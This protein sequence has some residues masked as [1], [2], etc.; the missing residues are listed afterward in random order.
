LRAFVEN[1]EGLPLSEGARNATLDRI[2]DFTGTG[3]VRLRRLRRTRRVWAA[4]ASVLVL[5]S[6]SL[7]W[8]SERR[9]LRASTSIS[10][11]AEIG[12]GGNRAI[13]SLP[14][15]RNIE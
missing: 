11:L 14:D 9:Y 4:A 5:Q 15:G 1:R 6:L 3:R 8:V 13:L 10:P 12:P 2:Y 7:Y